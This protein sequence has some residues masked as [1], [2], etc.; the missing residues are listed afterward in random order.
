VQLDRLSEQAVRVK[1][2]QDNPG[3]FRGLT[4]TFEKEVDQ[5]D[6]RHNKRLGD[7]HFN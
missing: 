1:D 2:E 5:Q 4:A 7:Q 6:Q 3:L